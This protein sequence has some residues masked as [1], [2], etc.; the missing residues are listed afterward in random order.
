MEARGASQGVSWL[1]SGVSLEENEWRETV[2]AGKTDGE[3]GGVGRL[4]IQYQWSCH[5][6]EIVKQ[7]SAVQYSVDPSL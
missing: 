1:K 5:T 6:C 2:T 7:D 4:K 3:D